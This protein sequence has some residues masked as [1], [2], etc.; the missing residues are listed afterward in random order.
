MN[1][2]VSRLNFTFTFHYDVEVLKVKREIYFFK[3]NI[4]LEYVK[5]V[6]HCGSIIVPQTG[7]QFA[8]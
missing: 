4:I 3:G 6:H 5:A 2:A 7:E 8:N 1:D